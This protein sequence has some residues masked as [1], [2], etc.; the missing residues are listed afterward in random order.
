MPTKAR[1][2][3]KA[4]YL[5]LP[6]E[7]YDQLSAVAEGNYRTIKAEAIE[8]FRR[9]LKKPEKVKPPPPPPPKRPVGR[10][11]KQKD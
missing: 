2:G 10:P 9:Y 4:L 1:P 7:L 6:P 8:A 3:I 5:E 11:R